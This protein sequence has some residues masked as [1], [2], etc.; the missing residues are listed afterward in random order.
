[1]SQNFKVFLDMKMLALRMKIFH[2]N[3]GAILRCVLF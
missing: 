2:Q 1:M 3:R